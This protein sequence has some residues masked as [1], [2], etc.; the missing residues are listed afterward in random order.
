MSQRDTDKGTIARKKTNARRVRGQTKSKRKETSLQKY[1]RLASERLE[2]I[3]VLEKLY[4][5]DDSEPGGEL[6]IE[7]IKLKEGAGADKDL[8]T[9]RN[10]EIARLG[11]KVVDLQQQN[12]EMSQ[13]INGQANQI[14][15]MKETAIELRDL[16]E[17]RGLPTAVRPGAEF[18]AEIP[19][20][21]SVMLANDGKDPAFLFA[22][23][24]GFHAGLYI[25]LREDTGNPR[26][27]CRPEDE[28]ESVRRWRALG[29]HAEVVF[30][31]EMLKDR[32]AWYQQLEETPMPKV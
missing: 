9:R 13:V 26:E 11:E 5:G 15:A 8:A 22:G 29:Y 25:V 7:I 20:D 6:K 32:I 30:G 23:V 2:R 14:A 21:L 3:C 31:S 18:L 17:G 24:R 19:D 1:R 12:E 28:P 16:L 27:K 4:Q 10:A